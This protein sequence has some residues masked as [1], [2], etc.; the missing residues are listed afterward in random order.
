MNKT[1]LDALKVGDSVIRLLGGAI[2][3]PVTITQIDDL[4][5]CGP[6]A[7]HR[8]TG[9]EIDEGLGW[10]GVTVTGSFLT[11]PEPSP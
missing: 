1:Q 5:H 11:A 10:D 9:C 6:W 8:A 2:A 4:I 7:F 3:M